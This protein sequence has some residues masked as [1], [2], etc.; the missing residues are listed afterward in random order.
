MMN[1]L[2][3]LF[4]VL[5]I[6]GILYPL[7]YI[8]AQ[9]WYVKNPEAEKTYQYELLYTVFKHK[10]LVPIILAAGI[11]FLIAAGLIFGHIV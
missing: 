1:F 11:L 8:F 6:E 5:G 7:M 3:I 4:I 10:K 2:F 9:K